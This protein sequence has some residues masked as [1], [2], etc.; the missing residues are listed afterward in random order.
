MFC[1]FGGDACS[2]GFGA[3]LMSNFV[4]VIVFVHQ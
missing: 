2:Y 1:R 3:A 4:V